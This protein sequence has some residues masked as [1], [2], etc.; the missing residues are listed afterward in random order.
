MI[1]DIARGLFALMFYTCMYC[2]LCLMIYLA[3]PILIGMVTISQDNY[4]LLATD[5]GYALTAG[6]I[7]CFVSIAVLDKIHK[8]FNI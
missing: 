2:V 4:Y 8:R 3:F 1:G 7:S 5:M 6:P